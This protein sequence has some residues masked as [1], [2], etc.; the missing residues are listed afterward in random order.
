MDYLHTDIHLKATSE[1]WKTG[2]EKESTSLLFDSSRTIGGSACVSVCVCICVL[3]LDASLTLVLKKTGSSLSL[4]LHS[5]L[6]SW[7]PGFRQTA[8]PVFSL[9]FIRPG[10]TSVNT[11]QSILSIWEPLVVECVPFFLSP[12]GGSMH[13]SHLAIFPTFSAWS[14]SPLLS[15]PTQNTISSILHVNRCYYERW[16]K[17]PL[18]LA[19][20]YVCGWVVKVYSFTVV[21]HCGCCVHTYVWGLFLLC[22]TMRLSPSRN[23]WTCWNSPAVIHS[24]V[25]SLWLSFTSSNHE[26]Q[27]ERQHTNYSSFSNILFTTSIDVRRVGLALVVEACS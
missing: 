23:F 10:L 18:G 14:S 24:P 22:N 11:C 15:H 1:G 6:L 20:W 17:T 7:P 13:Y 12:Y 9:W 2:E 3:I 27:L 8:P 5:L 26:K 4:P 25:K 16:S 19:I 21:W